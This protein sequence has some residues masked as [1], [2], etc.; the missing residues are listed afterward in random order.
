M[1]TTGR[2]SLPGPYSTQR[3][4]TTK[5]RCAA[6]SRR[7]RRSAGERGDPHG[8]L[9]RAVELGQ[10][11]PLPP[12]QVR[13]PAA[14]QQPLRLPEEAREQVRVAVALGVL[15]PDVEGVHESL[16]GGGEVARHVRIDRK[17]TRLN[18]SHANI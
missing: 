5:Y 12:P 7:A 8:P 13:L 14:H 15:E 10:K 4:L 9:A 1:P 11:H 17:S 16:G 18:S 3:R 2:R 6:P